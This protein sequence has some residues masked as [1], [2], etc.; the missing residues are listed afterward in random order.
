MIDFIKIDWGFFLQNRGKQDKTWPPG[1]LKNRL[2]AAGQLG[3]CIR[4]SSACW[5]PLHFTR[6]PHSCVEALPQKLGAPSLL[7]SIFL[8]QSPLLCVS[9]SQEGT[10]KFAN[11]DSSVKENQKRTQ[12]RLQLQK[13]MV[14]K[15]LGLPEG[16]PWSRP[17][18]VAG[19]P[20][21]TRTFHLQGAP[22]L[23]KVLVLFTLSVL[24]SPGRSQGKPFSLPLDPAGNS[25]D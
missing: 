4:Q 16:Q 3:V 20:L 13:D 19:L 24:S 15:P 17:V 25:L 5:R 10:S 22:A 1:P 21:G 14:Q 6:C 9:V 23:K 12:R 7:S 2:L 11:L 18:G 8:H